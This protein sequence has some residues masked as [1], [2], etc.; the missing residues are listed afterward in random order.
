MRTRI[1]DLLGTRDPII[2][3]GMQ[4]VGTAELASAVSNAGGLGVLTEL[5]QPDQEALAREIVRRR[6]T[7]GQPFGV[8]LTILPSVNPPPYETYLDV[9]IEHR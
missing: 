9:V 5:T 3:R 4:W 7:T 2:Q 8:N 6:G 1:T